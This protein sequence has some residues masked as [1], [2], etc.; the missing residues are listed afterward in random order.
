MRKV[1]HKLYKLNKDI[2]NVKVEE[3]LLPDNASN[4]NLGFQVPLYIVI[5]EV[6][7]GI[8]KTP[9]NYD[10]EHYANKILKDGLSGSKIGY[11]YLVGDKKIY[12]FIPD[13]CYA[14]HTGS[15]LN[16]CSIGIERLVCKG[17]SFCDALH[18]QAKLAATLM[19]K[20]NIPFEHVISH[21]TARIMTGEEVKQCPSRLINEQ[22]GGFEMFKKEVKRC[23]EFGDLFDEV[24]EQ[25]NNF[26]ELS[27]D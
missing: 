23:L 11:H 26:D 7:L 27:R 14:C 8:G 12:H 1:N 25:Y 19:V 5:H 2:K 10:M 9:A 3:K 16:F 24:F 22:Y 18:N 13:D 6:S 17:I 15:V 20:W 21:K 4:M